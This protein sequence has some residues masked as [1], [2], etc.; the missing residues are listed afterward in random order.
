[1]G[2]DIDPQAIAAAREN[3]RRNNVNI[4]FAP[5]D[6]LTPARFDLVVANILANPL[7]VLAPALAERVSAGGCIVLS[8]VLEEQARDVMAAYEPSFR[9][10]V[11]RR[12][13]GWVAL[14]G[15]R[16]RPGAAEP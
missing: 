14:T 10:A 4:R 16:G 1:M 12:E 3:A 6:A 7:I 5:P 2:T 9:I 8:G 11:W 15:E 13:D